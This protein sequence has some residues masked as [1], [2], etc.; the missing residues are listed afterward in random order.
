MGILKRGNTWWI[1]ITAP[2][3][4]RVRATLIKSSRR[5]IYTLWMT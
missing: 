1:D 4:Q 2:G 3:G 5:V